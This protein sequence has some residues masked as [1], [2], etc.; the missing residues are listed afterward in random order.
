MALSDINGKKWHKWHLLILYIFT[1]YMLLHIKE[2]YLIKS[3][4][5]AYNLVYLFKI[6]AKAYNHEHTG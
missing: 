4:V 6:N 5:F 2:L 1:N 3:Y